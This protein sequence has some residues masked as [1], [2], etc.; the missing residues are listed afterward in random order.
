M[1]GLVRPL[2]Q[3]WTG[4]PVVIKACLTSSTVDVG[5]ACLSSA[6]QPVTWG[7]AMDVPL[8]QA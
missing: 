6:K 8:H 2:R 4:T 1:R 5:L 7:A 3:S